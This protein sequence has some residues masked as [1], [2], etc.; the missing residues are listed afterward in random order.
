MSGFGADGFEGV[1][2]DD[3]P[4][5]NV[6]LF[7]DTTPPELNA[8]T[9]EEGLLGERMTRDPVLEDFADA[10][11]RA[12][13][14]SVLPGYVPPIIKTGTAVARFAAHTALRATARKLLVWAER[15]R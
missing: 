13:A 10:K 2:E 3:Q 6:E 11:A 8:D 12:A 9:L 5:D 7:G 4:G 14:D 1:V 15:F